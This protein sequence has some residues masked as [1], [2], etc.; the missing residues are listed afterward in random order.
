MS[1]LTGDANI[2][3][4]IGNSIANTVE[5]VQFAEAIFTAAEPVHLQWERPSANCCQVLLQIKAF[6]PP[7]VKTPMIFQKWKKK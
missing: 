7:N 5:S 1:S 2:I 3:A 6:V 4:N